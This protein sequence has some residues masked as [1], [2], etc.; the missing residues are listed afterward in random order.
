MY[1]YGEIYI[2]IYNYGKYLLIFGQVP[3]YIRFLYL[4]LLY[5][6]KLPSPIETLPHASYNSS[7]NSV[8]RVHVYIV[9]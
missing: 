8:T 9:K 6:T 4:F 7:S 2:S 5:R 1:N 3:T